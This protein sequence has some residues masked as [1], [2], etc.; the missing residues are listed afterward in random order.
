MLAYI[1]LLLGAKINYKLCP[2]P[3]SLPSNQAHGSRGSGKYAPFVIKLQLTG[4]YDIRHE[5][6][7]FILVSP[8]MQRNG[9]SQ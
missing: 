8:L 1:L 3:H 5:P 4:E 7:G 6:L 9:K 2:M